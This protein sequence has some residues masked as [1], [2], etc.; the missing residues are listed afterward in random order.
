MCSDTLYL[1]TWTI[2][3][4]LLNSEKNEKNQKESGVS[5]YLRNHNIEDLQNI[6]LHEA[7]TSGT[8]D[9]TLP[10]YCTCY[11]DDNMDA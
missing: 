5:P 9:P 8:L 10:T 3:Y 11:N 1:H 7:R 4:L 2:P 6:V